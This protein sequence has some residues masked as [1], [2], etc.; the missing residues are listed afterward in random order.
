MIGV[1]AF[2]GCSNQ[3]SPHGRVP[4]IPKAQQRC[5]GEKPRMP[6]WRK[7][8]THEDRRS[9]Q[10]SVNSTIAKA[11]GIEW[12]WLHGQGSHPG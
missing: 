11:L 5:C 1:G 12:P 7:T 6:S 10:L 2:F 9:H 3:K 8:P 4:T